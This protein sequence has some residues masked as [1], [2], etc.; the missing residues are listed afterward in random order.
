MSF[1]SLI[2][3]MGSR[4]AA[5]YV[6]KATR[7]YLGR[8]KKAKGKKVKPKPKKPLSSPR[9]QDARRTIQRRKARMREEMP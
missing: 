2:S 1:A 9:F 8:R 5:N 7:D 4:K 6:L 3:G